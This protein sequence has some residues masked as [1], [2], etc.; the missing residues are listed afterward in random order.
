MSHPFPTYGFHFLQPNE[1]DALGDVQQ[2]A[3]DA[4]DGYIF[5]VDLSYPHYL[6]DSHDDYPLAPESLEIGRDMY[7]P[8]Q[9][10]VFPDTA[11]QRKLTLNLKDKGKYVVHYRN[12]KL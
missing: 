9:R 8:G 5:E 7:S 6:H 3:D 1:I 12:L 4:E 11:P 2:L 10:A